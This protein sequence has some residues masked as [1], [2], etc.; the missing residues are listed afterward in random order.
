MMMI[1]METIKMFIMMT[2]TITMK[3]MV[4]FNT[5]VNTGEIN[6][7]VMIMVVVVLMIMY[8]NEKKKSSTAFRKD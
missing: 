7:V 8:S 5:K 6:E 1:A 3:L 4:V 2:K